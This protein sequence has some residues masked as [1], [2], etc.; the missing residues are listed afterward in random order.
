M[1]ITLETPDDRK[2]LSIKT[3]VNNVFTLRKKRIIYI[4]VTLKIGMSKIVFLFFFSVVSNIL[5]M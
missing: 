3:L 5:L 4:G 2:S 1:T